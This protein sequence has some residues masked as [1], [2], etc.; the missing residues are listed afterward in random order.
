MMAFDYHERY[1]DSPC[2]CVRIITWNVIIQNFEDAKEFIKFIKYIIL[3][4]YHPLGFR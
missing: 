2:L 3:K 1:R 4:K